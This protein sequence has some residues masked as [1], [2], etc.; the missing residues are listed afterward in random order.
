MSRCSL[1]IPHFKILQH[2]ILSL[3]L[4][5]ESV[6]LDMLSTDVTQAM[7]FRLAIVIMSW[8]LHKNVIPGLGEW[9]EAT[10]KI[11]PDS[12]SSNR[13]WKL[14]GPAW[15]QSSPLTDF[16]RHFWRQTGHWLENWDSGERWIRMF[17]AGDGQEVGDFYQALPSTGLPQL[18][19]YPD[20]K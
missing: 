16:T 18:M 8:A 20:K 6:H 12:L 19:N 3:Q 1:S 5:L 17:V 7:P 4:C 14:P 11:P 2:C 10:V 13:L 9:N 15:A